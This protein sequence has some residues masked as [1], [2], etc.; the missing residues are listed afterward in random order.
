MAN[1]LHRIKR[2]EMEVGTKEE[3]SCLTSEE[4]V[5]LEELNQIWEYRELTDTEIREKSQ[6]VWK[7]AEGNRSSKVISKSLT[8][9]ADALHDARVRVEERNNLI[10]KNEGIVNVG[11][12]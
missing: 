5:R 4:R 7:I 1:L 2:L 3:I 10:L 12:R 8:G 11:G 6:L 9:L